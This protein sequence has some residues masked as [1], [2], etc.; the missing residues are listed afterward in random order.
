MRTCKLQFDEVST[1]VS[2]ADIF[3]CLQRVSS[4]LVHLFPRQCISN[5]LRVG[6]SVAMSH[7]WIYQP[8]PCQ[9]FILFL[10]TQGRR[11]HR[12][13]ML[14]VEEEVQSNVIPSHLSSRIDSHLC[15]FW[16]YAR[17]K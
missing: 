17:G 6:L 9:T 3:G 7:V 8:K 13:D 11:A 16:R 15:L 2:A 5:W 12:N 14:R 4:A 10:S 1:A